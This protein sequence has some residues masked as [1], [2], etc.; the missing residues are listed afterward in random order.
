LSGSLTIRQKTAVIQP[1]GAYAI[2]FTSKL[3]SLFE[4][5]LTLI[6][7]TPATAVSKVAFACS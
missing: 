1:L 2:D 4:E 6:E 7:Q 3:L 5:L